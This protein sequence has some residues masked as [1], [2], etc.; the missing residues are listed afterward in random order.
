M[1]IIQSLKDI[2][3]LIDSAMEEG[4]TLEY[5]SK[6][7]ANKEIAKEI[8]AFAKSQGGIIIY[9]ILTKDRVP[10]DLI[11]ITEEH[12]EERIRNVLEHSLQPAI[13]GVEVERLPNPDAVEQAVL[14]I[15]IP[16]SI[17]APHMV[18]GRYYKRRG[19]VSSPMDH[20]EIKSVMLGSGRNVAL[21]FEISS[22]IQILD[23]MYSFLEQMSESGGPSKVPNLALIPLHT[24]AWRAIIAG[25][26]LFSFSAALVEQL[27]GA[28]SA[29][30]EI[31]SLIEWHR[32][33]GSIIMVTPVYDSSFKHGTYVPAVIKDKAG[34][35]RNQLI[36][37]GES[38]NLC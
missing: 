30:H 9:G 24:D 10:T 27:I 18:D 34:K 31:N 36:K 33:Q 2:Q 4:P 6:L 14:V 22:N 7:S 13:E 35:L 26:F 11:W 16:A 5:K 25:G 28:Y 29:V 3:A 21:R 32:I 38:I 1:V 8:C 17:H 12:A 23:K 15:Q 37:L 19:S 20:E